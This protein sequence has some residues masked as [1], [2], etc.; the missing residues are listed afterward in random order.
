MDSERTS[1][2]KRARWCAICASPGRYGVAAFADGA[3]LP[4]LIDLDDVGRHDGLRRA[5][6]QAAG[7]QQR[8][9]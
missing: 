6:H 5:P 8:E 4:G 9:H 7:H 2:T 3:H 1:V